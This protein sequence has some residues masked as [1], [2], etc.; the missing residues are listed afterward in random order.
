[1]G[2]RLRQ[3]AEEFGHLRGAFH[4]PLAVHQKFA[5]RGV[6]REAEADA[7]HDVEQVVVFRGGGAHAVG[8]EQR[9]GWKMAGFFGI[10]LLLLPQN[11]DVGFFGVLFIDAFLLSH[12]IFIRNNDIS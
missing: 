7:G 3:I 11:Y 12:F 6:E 5:A 4:V 9:W 8:G 1:M 10:A 2:E